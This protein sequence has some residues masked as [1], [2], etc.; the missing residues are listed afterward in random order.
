M[1]RSPTLVITLLLLAAAPSASAGEITLAPFVGFSTGLTL[2][3]LEIGTTSNLDPKS[4]YGLIAGFSL[5]PERWIEVLWIH[6]ENGSCAGCLPEGTGPLDLTIDSLHLG[7]VYKPGTKKIRPYAAASAGL[8]LYNPG[9][10]GQGT[11]AGFSFAL[12]GGADFILDDWISFRLDGRGWL[13]FAS[14]AL[15]GGC[16]GGCS[17]GFSGNGTFQIQVIAAFVIRVSSR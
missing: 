8:T 7:G 5:G 11:T 16:N 4:E 2:E 12:G 9:T 14:G 17:I 3:D 15:Y 6:Q 10:A 13:T 1:N